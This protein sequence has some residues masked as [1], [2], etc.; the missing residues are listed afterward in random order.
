MKIG[1]FSRVEKAVTARWKTK[2]AES[3]VGKGRVVWNILH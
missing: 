2:A 3:L 1:V